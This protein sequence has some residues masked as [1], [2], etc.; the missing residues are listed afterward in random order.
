MNIKSISYILGWI[1]NVEAALMLLPLI[2]SLIYGEKEGFAFLVVILILALI[3][4]SLTFKKPNNPSFHAR[5]GFAIT[6][7]SWIVMSIFGCL[8]F[9]ITG[10][11]PNFLDALFETVSGFTTT[12]SSIM[13]DV[14]AMC[15]A[16]MLWRCF[17][18]WVGGMGV[19]V[20]LL[21]LVPMVGGTNMQLMKAE[22]PG[23]SVGKLVPKVRQTARILYFLY[24]LLSVIMYILLRFGGMIPFESLCTVFGTAG[25]GGF[26][27]RNDSFASMSP[28]L[29]WIVTIFMVLFGVNFNVY[30]L[31]F[32]RKIKE[33][34]RC[35]EMRWYL[36][37]V[38][39]AILTITI[40]IYHTVQSVEL[41]L[42]QSAFQVAS[43]I[44]TTG[45]A[46]ANFDAWPDFSK[47]I[48]VVLM[49]CGACAGSTGGG[50]KVSRH[51]I[52][53]KNI[54][55]NL[56][57]YLHPRAVKN[58]RFERKEVDNAMLHS[59]YTYYTA[60]LFIFIGSVL[61]VLL[62]NKGLVTSFTAVAA[63]FNNIG[64][65]LEAVGPTANFAHFGALSKIVLILDMLI[66]RLEIFPVLILFYPA[67]WK[68]AYH[69]Y[70]A[71]RRRGNAA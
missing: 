23:P 12:G 46:S 56:N 48:L 10:E 22:S 53:V 13:T 40:N 43:I 62:E 16:S 35:E 36:S 55:R 38:G 28:Y 25:T 18:H 63:T 29:Q 26:G 41:A 67:L 21:A 5:E 44:S 69:S 57:S 45:Y 34:L 60:A 70:R 24:F 14:T 11:I 64:P 50:L 71:K 1:C 20:F 2:T 54:F 15:H 39:I 32:A 7:L 59:I 30:F 9:V 49:F 66:G 42:R 3:G 17:T 58:V 4:F 51:V 37:I 65:G 6:A 61:I 27:L 31:L 68:D 8:P 47:G 33:A 52:A 19:L